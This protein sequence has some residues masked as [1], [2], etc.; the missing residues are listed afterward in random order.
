MET[1]TIQTQ[2]KETVRN[3]YEGILNTGKLELLNTIFSE[4]YNGSSGPLGLKGVAGFAATINVLIMAFPDIKWT[5]EDLF[6]EGDKVAAKASWKGTNLGEYRGLP[7]TQKEFANSGIGIFQFRG[8]RLLMSG[9]KQIDWGF[10]N[11]EE[12]CHRIFFRHHLF[13]M[14]NSGKSTIKKAVFIPP[15]LLNLR[16]LFGGKVLS[17]TLVGTLHSL[18]AF[19]P[20]GRAYFARFFV[21]LQC[22]NHAD[23]FIHTSSQWEIINKRMANHTVF[24]H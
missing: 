14:E 11:K 13:K 21:L 7:P 23:G 1:E 10:F 19:F 4:E 3:L 24:I 6:A 20:I 9:W 5:I 18:V 12:L 22:I 15:F 17:D 16:G 8:G 2:N